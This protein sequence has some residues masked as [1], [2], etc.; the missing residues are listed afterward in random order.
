MTAQGPPEELSTDG[1]SVPGYQFPEEAARA[2]AHAAR[3]GAWRARPAGASLTA[4]SKTVAAGVAMIGA[5]LARGAGW[6]APE[7]FAGL[8][9]LY[10]IAQAPRASCA[11]SA[12]PWWRPASWA[13]RWRS[14]RSRPVSCTSATPAPWPPPCAR[15][16]RCARRQCDAGS[17]AATG[18]EPPASSSSP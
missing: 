18:Q 9:T 16:P 12:P 11:A 4:D 14:R 7:P 2:I 5:E 6:M 15:P 10:G 13:G 3:Y 8:L 1:F 17:V